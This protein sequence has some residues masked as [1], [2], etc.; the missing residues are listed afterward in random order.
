MGIFLYLQNQEGYSL[1]PFLGW[2]LGSHLDATYHDP[3]EADVDSTSLPHSEMV[4]QGMHGSWE[5]DEEVMWISFWTQCL[6]D[7][8]K[9]KGLI[10]SWI[11]VL[12]QIVTPFYWSSWFTFSILPSLAYFL[13]LAFP[14]TFLYL[15]LWD[16]ILVKLQAVFCFRFY[17]LYSSFVYIPSKK[18]IK[19]LIHFTSEFYFHFSKLVIG[20]KWGT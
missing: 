16:I 10:H 12:S 5:E 15:C 1:P 20:L 11:C 14:S 8:L 17:H 2:G 4:R 3:W 18:R 13:S 6:F 7:S 9:T 19:S